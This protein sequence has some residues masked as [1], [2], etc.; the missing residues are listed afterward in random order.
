MQ[1]KIAA[2]LAISESL[3][4]QNYYSAQQRTSFHKQPVGGGKTRKQIKASRKANKA[5]RKAK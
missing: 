2:M 1:N 4:T 5:R 3:S